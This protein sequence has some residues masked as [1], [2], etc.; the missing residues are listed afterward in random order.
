MATSPT[1]RRTASPN[2]WNELL[3]SLSGIDDPKEK[4]RFLTCGRGYALFDGAA[5]ALATRAR[6][7]LETNHDERRRLYE[8]AGSQFST[9]AEVRGSEFLR[10]CQFE[11][12]AFAEVV[13]ASTHSVVA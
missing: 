9:C 11:C 3:R 1:M 7:T 13:Q 5:I 4:L 12:E 2:A 10:A 6:A 8:L